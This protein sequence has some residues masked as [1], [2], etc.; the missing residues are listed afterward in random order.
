[1]LAVVATQRVASYGVS[2]TVFERE[3]GDSSQ[4][5]PKRHFAAKT[6]HRLSPALRQVCCWDE[7]VFSETASKRSKSEGLEL[8]GRGLT[9]SAATE[10]SSDADHEHPRPGNVETPRL[11][12]QRSAP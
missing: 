1:M 12:T 6:A 8:E 5:K 7:D 11:A 9:T 10:L 3:M 2:N 4:H